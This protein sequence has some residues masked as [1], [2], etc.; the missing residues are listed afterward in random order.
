M[1]FGPSLCSFKHALGVDLRGTLYFSGK[2]LWCVEGSGNHAKVLLLAK[3]STRHQHVYH[4]MHCLCHHQTYH[5]EARV[6]HSSTYIGRA[7]GVHLHG[8]HVMLDFNK[9]WQ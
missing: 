7:F 3:P 5:Q 9:A 4:T 6:V 2:A 8:L 1:P